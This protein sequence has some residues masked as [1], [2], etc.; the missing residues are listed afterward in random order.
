[1]FAWQTENHFT[2]PPPNS[3]PGSLFLS[4]GAHFLSR[5][6]EEEIKHFAN[7]AIIQRKIEM[8]NRGYPRKRCFTA[9]ERSN[10]SLQIRRE[11]KRWGV[12]GFLPMNHDNYGK[13]K[14][15]KGKALIIQ[16]PHHWMTKCSNSWLKIPHFQ[17]KISPIKSPTFIRRLRAPDFFQSTSLETIKPNDALQ[18]CLE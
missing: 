15:F 1:M 10:C 6:R 18:R 11:R 7:E 13:N 9:N 16:S 17:A 2:A 4:L 12:E 8:D 14:P 3:L 5:W